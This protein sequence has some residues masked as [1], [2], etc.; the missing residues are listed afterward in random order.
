MEIATDPMTVRRNRRFTEYSEPDVPLRFRPTGL[1]TKP[2][3]IAEKLDSISF[4]IEQML[5]S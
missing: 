5:K 4:R 2:D 1:Y 3:L